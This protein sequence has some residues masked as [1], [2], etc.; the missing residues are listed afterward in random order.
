MQ[1]SPTSNTNQVTGIQ[2]QAP[3]NKS[4]PASQQ[5][6]DTVQLSQAAQARLRSGDV[7]HD[8]DSH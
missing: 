6:A 3:T 7:D 5:Q 4:Q 8:G 1:V 2:G